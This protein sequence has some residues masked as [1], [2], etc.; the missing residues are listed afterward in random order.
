M[1]KKSKGDS[2][3]SYSYFKNLFQSNPE[4]L[5]EKSNSAI[6]AQYRKDHGLP[7]ETEVE[8]KVMNNLANQK[9][10]MRKHLRKRGPKKGAPGAKPVSKL[11]AL[12]IGIDHCLTTAR[13]LDPKGLEDVIN[14][15]R[16]ARNKVVWQLG[17]P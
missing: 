15:L 7:E 17:E 5:K 13:V 8:K 4:F 6:L 2:N 3:S 12:E 1:A 16:R 14:L 11:E 9:S 10:V